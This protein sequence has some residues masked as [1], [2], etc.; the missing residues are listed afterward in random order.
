M[1]PTPTLTIKDARITP[2]SHGKT[3]AR[4]ALDKEEISKSHTP[5]KGSKAKGLG[6]HSHMSL[7]LEAEVE[8]KAWRR[9]WKASSTNHK[10]IS[11]ITKLQSKIWRTSLAKWLSYCLKELQVSSLLIL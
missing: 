2:T 3:K 7:Q 8:R 11:K 5:I 10:Q 4:V 9:L 6:N 1:I